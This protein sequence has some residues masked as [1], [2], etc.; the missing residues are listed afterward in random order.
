MNYTFV[1]TDGS[2]LTRDFESVKEA[3]EYAVM[4]GDHLFGWYP[5]NLDNEIADLRHLFN[6][7]VNGTFKDPVELASGLLHPVISELELRNI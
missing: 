3:R 5:H 4:D 7:L 2:K 1:Y 6:H